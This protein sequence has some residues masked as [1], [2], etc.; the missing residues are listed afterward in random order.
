MAPSDRTES[1]RLAAL[2]D[3]LRRTVKP[4]SAASLTEGLNALRTRGALRGRKPRI[5]WPR[6]LL[7]VAV[8]SSLVLGVAAVWFLSRGSSL[9]ERPVAVDK[10]EGGKLLDGGYLS[11][12]GHAGIKLIFNEGSKFELA[13]GTRGRLRAVTSEGARLSIEH[14]TASFRITESHD[15]RWSVEAGPFVVKVRGTIFA[16]VWD[17]TLEELKVSLRRGRV[18]VSGPVVGDELLLQ[19]GQTLTVSLP[20]RQSVIKE[21]L[22]ETEDHSQAVAPT[23]PANSAAST[24]SAAAASDAVASAEHTVPNAPAAS[25]SAAPATPSERS[26]KEAI[27]TGQWDRI[28]AVVDRDG[29]AKTLGTLSSEDLFALADAA[30][31]RRR[32]DL[33]RA[34]LLEQRRRFPGSPRSLD[35]LFLL[36]RVEE[37]G[38]GGKTAAIKRY[39]EYLA[40]AP[41]GTYAAEALGRRMILT[42]DVE[43][44]ASAGRIAEEYLR[45][46]PGGSYAG[47][48][49]ALRQVP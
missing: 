25:V 35:A 49:R 9:S 45:R 32:T 46:F 11:E 19:S 28:L 36:G 12:V 17:P 31:Y 22:S 10:I 27:A 44:P 16:V 42:K 37:L 41:G 7:A 47:A 23:T 48:A 30:R 1:R 33:A 4:P 2:T 13:P 5:T 18:A 8:L 34:A 3:L 6:A 20:K 43:G 21:G 15:H 38:H 29:V 14:G 26:W 24:A 40:Q 39:D